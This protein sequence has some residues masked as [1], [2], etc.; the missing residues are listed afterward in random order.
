M[1][2]AKYLCPDCGSIDLT[3]SGQGLKNADGE[4]LAHAVC[5]NCGWKG[6]LKDTIGIASTER[7]WDAQRVGELLLRVVAIHAAGP[8]VQ[9]FEFIGILPKKKDLPKPNGSD[10]A[11]S[12]PKALADAVKWNEAAQ[13]ARDNV[14]RAV[15]EAVITR[16]FEEA[17]RQ[18]RIFTVKTNTPLHP[19]FE[20][21]AA[22]EE[23][24]GDGDL[25]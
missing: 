8:L 23:F 15:F 7:L 5:P 22:D 11:S 24:G 12:D 17:E 14:M 9:C 2:D 13:E 21:H 6:A 20:E 10:V 4:S 1:A 18:H 19:M 16:G 25:S 3:I